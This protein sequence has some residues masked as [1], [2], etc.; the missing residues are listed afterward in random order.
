MVCYPGSNAVVRGSLW[1]RVSFDWWMS[2]ECA[3]RDPHP[4]ILASQ[5]QLALRGYLTASL[6]R[7]RG[8]HTSIHLADTH[9]RMARQDCTGVGGG[10]EKKVVVQVQTE[11]Y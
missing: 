4:A 2:T 3:A 11:H 10:R 5:E 6:Y 1:H 7:L 8:V 9:Y